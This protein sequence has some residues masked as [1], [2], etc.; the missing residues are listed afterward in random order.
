MVVKQKKQKKQKK[1]SRKCVT[2]ILPSNRVPLLA[3]PAVQHRWLGTAGQASSGTPILSCDK[4]LGTNLRDKTIGLRGFPQFYHIQMRIF[5]LL[6]KFLDLPPAF[7]M[8]LD[9]PP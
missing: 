3:C 7:A 9:N 2:I 6:N 5:F 1:I 8:R 4:V